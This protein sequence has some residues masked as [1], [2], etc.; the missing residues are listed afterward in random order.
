MFKCAVI[1]WNQVASTSTLEHHKF[2]DQNV[3]NKSLLNGWKCQKGEEER[4]SLIIPF[5]LPFLF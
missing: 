5:F 2:Y 3:L 4:D 1:S